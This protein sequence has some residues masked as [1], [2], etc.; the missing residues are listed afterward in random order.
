MPQGDLSMFRSENQLGNPHATDANPTP[1]HAARHSVEVNMF[2]GKQEPTTPT[3]SSSAR[4]VSL[5]SSYSTNDLPTMKANG[6]G[7]AITPPKTHAEQFHQHNASLGRIPAGV[8]NPRS[9]K[10][11]PERE[12]SN[13]VSNGGSQSGLQATATPFGPQLASVTGSSLGGQTASSGLSGFQGQFYPYSIQPY[14]ANGMSVNGAAAQNFAA[15]VPYSANFGQNGM[16]QFARAPARPNNAP[17]HRSGETE[18]QQASR[19]ANLPLEQYRGEL[20][21]LCKDQHGCRYLQR[22]LEERNPEHV[23]LIFAETYMHVVELMTG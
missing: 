19:F 3:A 4:P 16:F 12:D 22:K 1:R 13:I 23:Q 14:N 15:Q 9:A 5:Q 18:A 17:T 21:N 20:Y 7:T 6:F 10:D 8:A 11:S 2:I